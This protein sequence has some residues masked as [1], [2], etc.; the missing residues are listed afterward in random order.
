MNMRKLQLQLR[1]V[2][3]HASLTQTGRGR[4]LRRPVIK[5]PTIRKP[6]VKKPTVEKPKPAKG[7]QR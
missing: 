3:D 7:G 4:R 2:G 5:R 1:R 6:T